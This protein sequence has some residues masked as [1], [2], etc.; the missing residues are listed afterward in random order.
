VWKTRSPSRRN[1]LTPGASVPDRS[2]VAARSRG[3]R[4]V[5]VCLGTFVLAAAGLLDGRRATTHWRFCG[6]LSRAYPEV[7]VVPDVLYVDEGDVLTSGGV[8]AG[9]D[10]CIHLVRKDFGA[11]IANSLAR[12]LVVGPHREG[13]QAQFVEQPVAV[14]RRHFT[15]Q[16][17]LSPIA[18][19]RGFRTA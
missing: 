3:C 1:T 2:L 13:G 7:H 8:A 4:I 14:F 18:Y 11:E 19:R 16:V 12:R 15:G 17:G 9:I 10:L 5:S 6:A